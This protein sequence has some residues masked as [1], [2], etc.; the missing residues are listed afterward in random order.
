[1]ITAL[2]IIVVQSNHALST[3]KIITLLCLFVHDNLFLFKCNN[4]SGLLM[5][6]SVAH[7]EAGGST[8]ALS[9]N[10]QAQEHV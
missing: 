6:G 10:Q 8:I 7:L 1:M 5:Y 9:L 4:V 2:T 3:I